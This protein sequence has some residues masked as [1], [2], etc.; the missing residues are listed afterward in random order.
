MKK[1]WPQRFKSALTKRLPID[2]LYTLLADADF[3]KYQ[4]DMDRQIQARISSS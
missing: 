4:E 3:E 2:T 1:H